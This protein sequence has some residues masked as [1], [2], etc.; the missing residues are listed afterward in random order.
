MRS[1]P[2]L[3]LHDALV[4]DFSVSATPRSQENQAREIKIKLTRRDH[5]V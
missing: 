5:Q 3:E 2:Q 1:G 4:V